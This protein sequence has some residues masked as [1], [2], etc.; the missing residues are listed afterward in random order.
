VRVPAGARSGRLSAYVSRRLSSRR[1]RWIR[2]V[3]KTG[4]TLKDSSVLSPAPISIPG[5]SLVE[6]AGP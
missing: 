3:A 6:T 4:T 1:S 5:A 2:I